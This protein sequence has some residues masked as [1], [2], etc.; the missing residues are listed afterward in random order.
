MPQATAESGTAKPQASGN[1]EEAKD[2]RVR[3][4]LVCSVRVTLTTF[5][6]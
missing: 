5:L 6:L 4:R 2:I 3:L 1:P